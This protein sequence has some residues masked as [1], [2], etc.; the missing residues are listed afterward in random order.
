MLKHTQL[1]RTSVAKFLNAPDKY[2]KSPLHYAAFTNN[3][4]LVQYLCSQGGNLFIRDCK[5][6]VR[7]Y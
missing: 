3:I 2:G 1:Y 7:Y 4:K 5:M 6:R